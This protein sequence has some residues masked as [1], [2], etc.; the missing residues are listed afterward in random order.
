MHTHSP[1][2]TGHKIIFT[3]KISFYKNKIKQEQAWRNT[4]SIPALGRQRQAEVFELKTSQQ[5][6]QPGCG[7][8]Q[9][10]PTPFGKLRQKDLI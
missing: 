10:S 9:K 2:Y 5:Q 6:N 7:G 1:R 4:L 8:A 3:K